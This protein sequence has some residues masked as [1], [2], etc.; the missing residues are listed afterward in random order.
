LSPATP[1]LLAQA[2]MEGQVAFSL[3]WAA[4]VQA[5]PAGYG[6]EQL[7]ASPEL[8]RWFQSLEGK[9][10][11]RPDAKDAS[12]ERLVFAD[13]LSFVIDP[14]QVTGVIR[15]IDL[16]EGIPPGYPVMEVRCYD[17]GA[18]RKPGLEEKQVEF[19]AVGIGGKP[20]T[21]QLVFSGQNPDQKVIY[22]RFPYAV[23]MKR[24]FRFRILSVFDDGTLLESPWEERERWSAVVDITEKPSSSVAVYE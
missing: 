20:V 9:E 23:N 17:F 2:L 13:V 5:P 14:E 3:A 21:T 6:L 7:R 19:E 16:N 24:P 1:I 15:K 11:S 12:H 4:F 18:N 8:V 22:P 10:A